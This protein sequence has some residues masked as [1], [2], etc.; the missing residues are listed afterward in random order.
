MADMQKVKHT[1]GK[2]ETF[3]LGAQTFAHPEQ[4]ILAQNFSGHLLSINLA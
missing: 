2:N 4:F 3:A 1:V